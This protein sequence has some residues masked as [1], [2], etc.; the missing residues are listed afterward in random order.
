MLLSRWVWQKVRVMGRWSMSDRALLIKAFVVLTGVRI[1][2][3]LLPFQTLLHRLQQVRQIAAQQSASQQISV[4]RLIWA[5][6]VV[7]RYLAPGS[8]CLARAL[9]TQLI[10]AWHG[11]SG[12]LRIGVAKSEAGLLE[13]H[14]WV[15]VQKQVVIGHLSDLARYQPMPNLSEQKISY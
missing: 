1:G 12:E 7:S 2:L 15:E 11:H 9:T 4:S 3:W 13:A 6:N 10:L 5:V 14:A 8:K